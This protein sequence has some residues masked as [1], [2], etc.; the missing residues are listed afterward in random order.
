MDFSKT[1]NP[2]DFANPVTRAEMFFGRTEEM[3]EIRYYLDHARTAD[4]PINLA[5]LGDRAAGKTSILNMTEIHAKERNCCTT[6][7]DLDEDDAKSQFLFFYKMFD[8]IF[9]AACQLNAFGGLKGKTYESYLNTTTCLSTDEDKLFLPFLFPS[10]YALATR[11]GNLG[12]PVSDNA[13]KHDLVLIKEELK[14]PVVVLFDESNVLAQ[15]RVLLEKLRN[16]FMNIPGYMLVLTGTPDLFPIMDDVFS[17]IVRQFKKINV[18]EFEKKEDIEHCVRKPLQKFGIPL[19]VST[20]EVN[21]I[22]ELSGGRPYEIQLICHLLFRRIQRKQANRMRLD[23]SVL[24]ELRKEL[25]SSQDI[26][27]RKVLGAVM[28]LNQRQLQVLG[29]LTGCDGRATFDELW[30]LHYCFEGT[31]EFTRN[32]VEAEFA[33]LK[34]RGILGESDGKINFTGD[35]FDRLYVKYFAAEQRMK[36]DIRPFPLDVALMFGMLQ[37]IRPQSDFSV[38]FGLDAW[39]Q[40]EQTASLLASDDPESDPFREAQFFVDDLYFKMIEFRRRSE[41]PALFVSISLSGAATA[42]VITPSIRAKDDAI[43]KLRRNF[44]GIK[45]RFENI[46]GSLIS[47]RRS[48]TVIGVERLS[49]KVLRTENLARKAGLA[50]KHASAMAN[51]WLRRDR[52]SASLHAKLAYSYNANLDAKSSN[53]IGYFLMANDDDRNA[54]Q[55]LFRRAIEMAHEDSQTRVLATYNLAMT[56][57]KENQLRTAIELLQ[58]CE[59][60]LAGLSAEGKKAG[61]LQVPTIKEGA[62]VFHEELDPDIAQT[63]QRAM[64]T[65]AELHSLSST[66]TA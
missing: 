65:V 41:I 44:S 28:T 46:G 23:L 35:S 9:T 53:N 4:R 66:A 18:K 37:F 64:K 63:Y 58:D 48:L 24:E 40:Y 33:A 5:L 25:A 2:Y 17:P 26:S 47:D 39:T 43:E 42:V 57:A 54:A 32:Q 8:G 31:R 22:H 10:Q 1:P 62:L 27:G 19:D 21:D 61:C 14:R 13:I 52:D 12:A 55:L 59:D 45:S 6:R 16:I 36:V 3:T 11:A 51:S 34:S 7:V 20:S 60:K 50:K 56:L 30:N 15:S 38:D 49:E 29:M